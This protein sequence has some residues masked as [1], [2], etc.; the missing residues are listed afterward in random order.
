[1]QNS[2][3]ATRFFSGCKWLSRMLLSIAL[4]ISIVGCSGGVSHNESDPAP[5][6]EPEEVEC[7]DDFGDVS[8]CETRENL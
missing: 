6:L 1:M 7:S 8:R 2:I 5:R 3:S 4:S